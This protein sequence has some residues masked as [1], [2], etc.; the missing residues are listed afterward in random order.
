MV[1]KKRGKKDNTIW[2]LI[3]SNMYSFRYVV[4]LG[5]TKMKCKA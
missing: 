3:K 4:S 5:G 2:Y 1:I